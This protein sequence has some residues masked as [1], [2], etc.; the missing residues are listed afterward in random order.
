M[1]TAV[2]RQV[3]VF[4]RRDLGLW[5]LVVLWTAACLLAFMG[6]SPFV[7]D[8]HRSHV[9]YYDLSFAASAWGG[10][11]SILAM[12]SLAELQPRAL[13][14]PDFLT[15]LGV[16]LAATALFAVPPVAVLLAEGRSPR[17]AGMAHA[18]PAVIAAFGAWVLCLRLAVA[19]RVA[20]F[21]YLATIALARIL[22]EPRGWFSSDGPL[23]PW[24]LPML[25][26]A[27]ARWLWSPARTNTR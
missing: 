15:E 20:V 8:T 4:G 24:I 22:P 23:H 3:S 11:V 26:I 17:A 9:V 14:F 1:R 16:F 2:L 27:L 18:L 7:A 12:R 13:R 6:T 19:P 10:S 25:G 5:V 21:V